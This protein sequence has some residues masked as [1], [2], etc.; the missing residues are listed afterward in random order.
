MSDAGVSHTAEEADVGGAG[1]GVRGH[2]RHLSGDG[3]TSCA[4]PPPSVTSSSRNGGDGDAS[5]K[6]R[7][8]PGS[9]GVA[10]LTPE[11]LAK[12]RA[13][14]R[15]PCSYHFFG[16]RL[17]FFIVTS[18]TYFMNIPLEETILRYVHVASACLFWTLIQSLS[19]SHW[20]ILSRNRS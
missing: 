3:D 18:P 20:L 9:R 19:A 13:N 11:Q 12:K 4:S 5:K 2:K 17:P 10:N 8:G 15:W 14:G 16:L 6:R 1:G 7:T